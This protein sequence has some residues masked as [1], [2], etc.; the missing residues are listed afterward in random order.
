MTGLQDLPFETLER[1]CELISG[2]RPSNLVPFS[3]VSKKC[4]AASSQSLWHTIRLYI[5]SQD[6]IL[7]SVDRLKH[8]IQTRLSRETRVRCVSI[9]CRPSWDDRRD[10]AYCWHP[11]RVY[12][13]ECAWQPLADVLAE[14]Q[15]LSEMEWEVDKLPFCV[16]QSL[17]SQHPGCKL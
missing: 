6:Q 4:L 15:P 14:M 8:I 3:E 16:L 11:K 1:I 5:R 7:E 12:L 17:N 2:S 9:S 10:R 13:D